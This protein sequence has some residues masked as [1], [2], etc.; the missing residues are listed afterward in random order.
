MGLNYH[1]YPRDGILSDDTQILGAIE[2]HDSDAAVAAWR[3]N[4][5]NCARYMVLQLA[6]RPRDRATPTC[7]RRALLSTDP[8]YRPYS[9]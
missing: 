5:D 8:R 6:G 7:N 4:I 2:A 3:S 9:V 1:E